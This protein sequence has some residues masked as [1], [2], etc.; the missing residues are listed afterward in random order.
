MELVDH[1]AELL[2]RIILYI[3]FLWL[4]QQTPFI[5]HIEEEELWMYR[6]PLMPS[7]V[8]KWCLFFLLIFIPTVIFL[9][10]Y[11]VNQRYKDIVKGFY[12]LTLVYMLS[13][14]FTVTLKL[15]VGRP[16]PNFFLRCFP[17]GY[18]TDINHCTGEYK[19]HMDARK[20]FPSAHSTFAFSGMYFMSLRMCKLFRIKE[21]GRFKGWKCL[22]ISI[23]VIIAV[24][25][26]VSRTC[27]Y[28]HHYSDVFGGAILGL[29]IAHVVY[30]A[31]YWTEGLSD[32]EV[33]KSLANIRERLENF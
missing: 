13:G 8:P 29:L 1:V 10:E 16:R 5:R 4:D 33:Q 25:I 26:G 2:L 31:F 23:P 19:G 18:G 28:H 21:R 27:D 9:A 22:L 11:A 17:D 14:I 7:I 15:L 30:Y 3:I 6:Y 32:E 12:A 20:S 24:L